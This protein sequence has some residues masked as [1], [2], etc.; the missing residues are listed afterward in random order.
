MIA[1]LLYR[2]AEI[3]V[4]T[5][6]PAGADRLGV[7]LARAAFVLRLPARRVVESNLRPLLPGQGT[8]LLSRHARETFEHFAL[9]FTDF[10]RLSGVPRERLASAVELRGAEHLE[11]ARRSGRGVIVLSAHVGSWER[12][13]AFLAARGVRLHVAARTHAS[14]RVESLFERRRLA[15]GIRRLAGHPLWLSAARALRRAEWVAVM[16]DRGVP[17]AGASVCAWAAALARRTGALVLPA[18]MVR[19]E[20]G[21]YAACFEAPLSPEACAGG[22]FRAVMR[23]SLE[24]YPGQWCAFEALP[25]GLA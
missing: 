7:A 14:A 9:G 16:S 24:R 23:R 13:A 6:P 15:F 8:S 4:R 11:R 12:G 25:G 17:G 20:D 22:A 21:R 19:L 2:I 10:L 1:W 5:L 18:L 3:L